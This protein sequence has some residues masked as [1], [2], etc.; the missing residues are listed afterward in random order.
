MCAFLPVHSFQLQSYCST[1]APPAPQP[2]LL[3]VLVSDMAYSYR[4]T[5]FLSLLWQTSPIYLYTLPSN[6]LYLFDSLHVSTLSCHCLG[7]FDHPLERI[8]MVCAGNS[9]EVRLVAHSIVLSSHRCP[10]QSPNNVQYRTVLI[11]RYGWIQCSMEVWIIDML[12]IA[13]RNGTCC[14]KNS[15]TRA[16]GQQCDDVI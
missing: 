7:L 3:L 16:G 13:T 15:C 4:S 6:L 1:V 8:N 9:L 12:T 14:L 10:L 2:L 11:P 5:I